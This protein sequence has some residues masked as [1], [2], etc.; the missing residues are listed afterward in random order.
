MQSLHPGRPAGPR[1][2]SASPALALPDVQPLNIRRPAPS[3]RPRLKLPAIDFSQIE[4]GPFTGEYTGGGNSVTPHVNS[5][6]MS[7]SDLTVRP[8]LTISPIPR[9]P[10][11]KISMDDIRQTVRKFDEWSDDY[12]ED[13]ARLGEGAGGAVYKVK[14]KRTGFFMARKTITTLEAP[15]KQLMREIKIISSTSH[16]N[17]IHFYGAYISP[18]SSEVKVLMEYCEGGSLESVG[19]RLK[20]TDKRVT[21]NVAGRLAEGILQGLAYLHKQKTIHRDIK[22]P[23]ILLTREGIVKLCDFGVSGE[24]INSMAGTFTGTSLY[25]APERLSGLEYTIRSDV[26]STGISLLELVQNRFPFPSDLAAIELMMYITQYEP[27]ELEDDGTYTYSSEMKDFIK[28]ALTRDALLRP[29][30]ASLL[31]HPWIA[32]VMQHE[33]NMAVWIR[34]VWGWPKTRSAGETSLRPGSSRS[35]P[36]SLEA[37]MAHMSLAPQA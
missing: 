15:M 30:P 17:I 5:S 19:K 4:G 35:D 7:P 36:P 32:N 28:Q 13:L 6:T 9:A 18:S 27:P 24:L 37:A 8:E 33:V 26:W 29:T 25:M 14:D 31:E 23:N 20:E 21:E 1:L 16:H 34:K 3:P 12:L 11:K 22:P 2:R 10:T